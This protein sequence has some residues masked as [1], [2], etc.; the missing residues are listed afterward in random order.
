[1][2]LISQIREMRATDWIDFY[3][4][5]VFLE[6]MFVNMDANIASDVTVMWHVQSGMLFFV[7]KG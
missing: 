1:M 3:T 5:A 7:E 4:R 2:F 6:A